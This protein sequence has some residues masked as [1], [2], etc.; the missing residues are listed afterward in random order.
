MEAHRR[1]AAFTT[2]AMVVN[3]ALFL[4][5]LSLLMIRGFRLSSVVSTIILGGTL[6]ILYRAR[7]RSSD[8]HPTPTS[9]TRW[10][11]ATIILSVLYL[12]GGLLYVTGHESRLLALGLIANAIILVIAA[13]Q[14]VRTSR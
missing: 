6:P 13:V 1:R 5:A 8:K 4:L 2:I 11:F 14:L 3:S 9:M 7:Q 12:L 10:R